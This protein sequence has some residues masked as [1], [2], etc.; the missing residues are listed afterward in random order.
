MCPMRLLSVDFFC[1]C[2]C[3][4]FEY[5]RPEWHELLGLEPVQFT[6]C[7]AQ[8][9]WLSESGNRSIWHMALVRRWRSSFWLVWLGLRS[10]SFA[11]SLA[12]IW[13]VRGKD[14]DWLFKW[15]TSS[16]ASAGENFKFDPWFCWAASS[17]VSYSQLIS[18]QSAKFITI[19]IKW[20][21]RW[22]ISHYE[23][24]IFS[25]WVQ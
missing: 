18:E 21:S 23:T 25:I 3:F 24:L 16:E 8:D 6:F 14:K 5:R 2:F 1:F 9:T 11:C 20:I 19:P 17:C 12:S 15:G 7:Q 13:R 22:A 10:K 4:Y